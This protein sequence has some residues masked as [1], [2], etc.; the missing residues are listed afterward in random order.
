MSNL[1]D[2]DS[3]KRPWLTAFVPVA[4]ILLAAGL[5]WAI[6]ASDSD[7]DG[8]TGDLPNSG[9]KLLSGKN[10]YTYI[11]EIELYPSNEEGKPWDQ[12]DD[13]PDIKYQIKWLG[14]EVFESSVKDDSLLANWSGLQIDLNWSDLLGKTLSPNETIQAARI[15]YDALSSIEVIV[16]DSDLAKDDLAGNLNIELKTL[17]IGKNRK[18]FPKKTDNCIRR[19]EITVLPIDS[20][21]EDLAQFM[22]E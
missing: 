20:T 9:E 22:K 15:R 19:I 13:G 21:L 8:L 10:Y 6:S 12:G 17:R 18:D 16:K 14:N 1:S 2:F 5:Y 3:P 11:S 4:V 7:V